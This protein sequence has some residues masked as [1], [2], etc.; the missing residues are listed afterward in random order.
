MRVVDMNW[1]QVEEYLESDDRCVLPIGST[2]QHGYLSLCTDAI[3][4]ERV[5]I[6]AAEPVGVPT[7]P[8]IPFGCS[9]QFSA[10]PGTISL[11]TETLLGVVRDAVQSMFNSGF[12]CVL[13]VNGHGGNSA[14]GPLCREL[15]AV[16]PEISLRFHD[17]WLGPR[18]VAKAKEIAA[19]PSHANW[20]EN[21]P[22][23][24][25]AD[26]VLPEEPKPPVDVTGIRQ[27]SPA[28]VRR[29][30]GDGSFGGS[31]QESG[32]AMAELWAVA[33]EETRTEL[34]RPWPNRS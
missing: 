33:V 12:R 19:F 17:W 24:R 18:V 30:I 15:M 20:M 9:P 28:G 32:Q 27:S 4:A 13:I 5:A 29:I 3:L 11:R 23:T 2:E 31:Y 7:Y 25:L 14:V 6:E 26:V 1:K 8:A 22:W 10:Y 16:F 21:F 34:E